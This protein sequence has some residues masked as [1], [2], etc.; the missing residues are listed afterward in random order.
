M[1]RAVRLLTALAFL[2]TLAMPVSGCE[3]PCAE[4]EVKVCQPKTRAL[5]RDYKTHCKLMGD[6]DRREH[7]SKDSCKS[8]IK[9]LSS[10]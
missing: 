7:L 8:L 5:K 4:L 6:S 1:T 3:D 10:R 2:L 9:H